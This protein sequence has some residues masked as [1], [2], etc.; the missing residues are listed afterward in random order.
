M[1]I[2]PCVMPPEGSI[3]LMDPSHHFEPPRVA[4]LRTTA[5]P[6]AAHFLHSKLQP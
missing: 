6:A 4:N 5:R 1:R 2:G 3:E